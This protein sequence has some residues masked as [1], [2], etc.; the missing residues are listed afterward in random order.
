M[1]KLRS[2]VLRVNS[3]KA[4]PNWVMEA[5]TRCR[6]AILDKEADFKT[7]SKIATL[8]F[9]APSLSSTN[10]N[11]LNQCKS[12]VGVLS[13]SSQSDPADQQSTNIS[14]ATPSNVIGAIV[15]AN[16]SFAHSNSHS[17]ALV[18][19]YANTNSG[20]RASAFHIDKQFASFSPFRSRKSVGRWFEPL[21][22]E[23]AKSQR[24]FNLD[25]FKSVSMNTPNLHDSTEKDQLDLV[26]LV[27]S[28]DVLLTISDK[29]PNAI[30]GSLCRVFPSSKKIGLVSPMTPFLTGLTH[31][32]FING[33]VVDGGL[34]G[35]S[36]T[37]PAEA[38]KA[39]D[40]SYEYNNFTPFGD[41]MSI[42]SCQG[43]IIL[44]LD[45]STATSQI[46]SSLATK[47]GN[48]PLERVISS[49]KSL[50]IEIDRVGNADKNSLQVYKI[51]AGDLRKGNIAVDT[52]EDLKVGMRVRFLYQGVDAH[53]YNE[54]TEA[55]IR[56]ATVRES[57]EFAS[58]TDHNLSAQIL[59]NEVFVSDRLTVGSETGIVHPCGDAFEVSRVP[60]S[61]VELKI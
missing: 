27:P 2:A 41:F 12:A 5:V 1:L 38:K 26:K 34:V 31:T 14:T 22:L 4:S 11:L 8:L 7:H 9:V 46:L 28:P 54:L 16:N 58:G 47:H 18:H 33:S 59:D 48:K 20:A 43:N 23:D 10:L 51:V 49:D 60:F 44:T 24:D 19:L 29:D 57:D 39:A 56:F 25:E 61:T 45:S 53:V 15:S 50:Y 17:I 40:V 21:S 36:L 35:L 52:V 37:L 42:T 13:N 30:W 55:G 32:H 3:E 6:A